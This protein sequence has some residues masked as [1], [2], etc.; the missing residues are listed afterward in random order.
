[1][2]CC[3]S[4]RLTCFGKEAPPCI[5]RLIR[6]HHITALTFLNHRTVGLSVPFCSVPYKLCPLCRI[7]YVPTLCLRLHPSIHAFPCP[8]LAPTLHRHHHRRHHLCRLHPA[9]KNTRQ[10]LGA[11]ALCAACLQAC[12]LP[13]FRVD[14]Q[15]GSLLM[16]R[17]VDGDGDGRPQ[18][19][20]ALLFQPT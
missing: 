8:K 11:A 16:S 17:S 15:I 7:P 4:P 20:A 3:T 12:F 9:Q 1:M 14:V 19:S 10:T 6:K 13:L 18:T 2:C 5:T